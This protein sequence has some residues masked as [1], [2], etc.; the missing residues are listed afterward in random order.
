MVVPRLNDSNYAQ[1]KIRVRTSIMAQNFRLWK[2]IENGPNVP[3]KKVGN[4]NVPKPPHECNSHELK[5]LQLNEMAKHFLIGTMDNNELSKIMHCNTA[6]EIWDYLEQL[7]EG[8]SRIKECRMNILMSQYEEFHMYMHENI[9]KMYAR[10]LSITNELSLLGKVLSNEEKVVKILRS[11]PCQPPWDIKAQ[12]LMETKSHNMLVEELI[13]SLKAHEM[14]V[15]HGWPTYRECKSPTHKIE[16]KK[17]MK[18]ASSSWHDSKKYK[19]KK[20]L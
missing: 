14:Q 20:K 12:V 4:E 2:I 8:T 6:K 3:M 19:G 17:K 15:M 7:Y 18:E 9:D 13:G 16:G 1:W 10:F 11:L 5:L